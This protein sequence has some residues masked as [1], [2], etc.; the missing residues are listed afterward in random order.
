[1]SCGRSSREVDLQGEELGVQNEELRVQLDEITARDEKI[2]RY[3]E[4]SRVDE[5]LRKNEEK[6][7]LMADFTYDWESWI[8]PD[9]KYIYISPSCERIT[10]YCADKFYRDPELLLEDTSIRKI[11]QRMSSTKKLTSIVRLLAAS[12]SGL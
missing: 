11:R 1:M 7:R 3:D 2:A 5:V 4:L 6:F 10:G 9:E 12:M 8:G